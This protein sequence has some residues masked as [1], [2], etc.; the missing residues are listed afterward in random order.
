MKK[1]TGL[2]TLLIAFSVIILSG[3]DSSSNSVA[4]PVTKP[5]PIQPSYGATNV[6]TSPLFKW[7]NTANKLE[8][9]KSPGFGNLVHSATVSGQTYQLTGSL[10]KNT[11]YYWRVGEAGSTTTWSDTWKFTTIP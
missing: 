6:S 8:I 11:S 1:I 3:C 9:S 10:E 7:N 2:I 4:I 5:E